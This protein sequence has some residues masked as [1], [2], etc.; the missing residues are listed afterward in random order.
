ME[1]GRPCPGLAVGRGH[2][3]QEILIC[4]RL[5]FFS[6]LE[7]GT[8]LTPLGHSTVTSRPFLLTHLAWPQD[9]YPPQ[10]G[11]PPAQQRHWVLIA[12]P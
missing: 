8:P 4:V 6:N 5:G 11:S 3:S 12:G 10:H 2:E 1:G 9:A 7:F